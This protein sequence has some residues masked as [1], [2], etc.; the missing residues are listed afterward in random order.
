MDSITH[1]TV[2]A[3]MLLSTTDPPICFQN[4]DLKSMLSAPY[5]T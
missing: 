4:S 1:N 2:L 5:F 3:V